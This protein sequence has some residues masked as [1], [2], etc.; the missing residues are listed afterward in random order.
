MK[1]AYV[2]SLH[3]GLRHRHADSRQGDFNRAE[4]RTS[5]AQRLLVDHSLPVGIDGR[6]S[7]HRGEGLPGGELGGFFRCVS[8]AA[9]L[10]AKVL[11]SKGAT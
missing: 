5:T 6:Q 11:E 10:P 3:V 4:N 1:S 2:D 8:Q 7:G 9:A